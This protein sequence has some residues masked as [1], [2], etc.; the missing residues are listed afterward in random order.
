MFGT[1]IRFRNPRPGRQGFRKRDYPQE[2]D[3]TT[4]SY[5]PA[6]PAAARPVTPRLRLTQRGRVVFATLAAVPL[7]I[8]GLVFGLGASG[9]VATRD[10]STASFATVTVDAG[11]SLWDLAAEIAP[12]ADPREVAAQIVSLNQLTSTVLQPG[13]ELAVPASYAD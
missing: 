12:T 4:L 1:Q 13:Q 6:P 3:M 10:A 11:Q 5:F 9:A 8:A 2:D 7:V